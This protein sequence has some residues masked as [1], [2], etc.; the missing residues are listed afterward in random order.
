MSDV[1]ISYG[2]ATTARQARS[3][4]EALRA[5]GY[6]VWFDEDLPAH[7]AFR[8]EILAQLN[9]AKAALVIWSAEAASSDWVLS[10]ADRAREAGK[11]VQ[12]RID[13]AP[14]PMPFDQ[15]QCADLSGW[16]GEGEHPA[17][18]KVAASVE[19]LVRPAKGSRVAPVPIPATAATGEPL[20][21][22]LAFDNL[23][24]D[25]QMAYFSDGVSEEIQQTVARG[26]DLK[27]IGRTSSFQL[28]GPD[29]AVRKVVADLKA[30]HILDGSVRRYGS[31]VRISA[32]LIEC[33]GETTLWS[34]RY[35]RDLTDF[36]ALQDEIAASV[37][38]A[39]KIALPRSPPPSPIEPGAFDLFLRAQAYDGIGSEGQLVRVKML[40]EVVARAPAFARGWALLALLRALTLRTSHDEAAV[41]QTREQATEAAH[42]A[43][44]LDPRMGLAFQALSEIEPWAAYRAREALQ[45]RAL[46]AAPNDAEV[47]AGAGLFCGGVGRASDGLALARRALELDPLSPWATRVL[48]LQ[49]GVAG[50]VDDQGRLL[51]AAMTRWP[52][53]MAANAI[54]SAAR[55][56][57][58]AKV[59][60]LIDA[61]SAR[62]I[63]WDRPRQDA[64]W[65]ARNRLEPDPESISGYLERQRAELARTG[66]VPLLAPTLLFWLGLNDDAFGLTDKA[67]FAHMF[68]TPTA[69]PADR[70][71]FGA[72]FSR[73]EAFF[74]DRRFPRLCAK[75]GLCDYWVETG[76]WPD[77]AD[78]VSYDFRAEVRRLAGAQSPA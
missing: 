57:D 68:D 9:A 77:C 35:D 69:A 71:Y 73:K 7:R 17:W 63:G 60:S 38:A 67:S 45:E 70:I 54:I 32:Q 26:A 76:K 30:T 39:L 13:G 5:A 74:R 31:R 49:L 8:Q 46:A 50:L 48:A 1:F 33:D 58:R 72:I 44:Q 15:I 18:T 59:E 24:D 64:I 23:S 27:V 75:L 6:S 40:E 34:D 42:R 19:D 47:L 29:K 25:R 20:L 3:A 51:D 37:A 16:S 22:V 28:R 66:T 62:S 2:H 36:F 43:L 53:G 78:E 56:G 10:E 11:L 4:A 61:W 41:G 21:A 14:L 52:E 12:L 55:R 65:F